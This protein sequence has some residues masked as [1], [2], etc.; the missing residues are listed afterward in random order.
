[1]VKSPPISVLYDN[2]QSD[3]ERSVMLQLL[4]MQST[5][6]LLSIRVPLWIEVVAPDWVLPMD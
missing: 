5:T 3:R 1:M 2:K 4:E 6:S